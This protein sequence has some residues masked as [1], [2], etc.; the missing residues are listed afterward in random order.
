MTTI[1][2]SLLSCDFL[3]IETELNHFKDI[4]NIWF[5]LDIMDGHF[6]PNLTFG[7]PIVKLISQK[8]S[9]RSRCSFHGFKSRILS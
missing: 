3:N 8:T 2:P 6:V 1:S 4:S 7:Q 9:N 5:H